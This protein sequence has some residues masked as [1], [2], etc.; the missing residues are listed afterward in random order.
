MANLLLTKF[1]KIVNCKCM[2]LVSIRKNS[3]LTQREA[4]SICGVPYRT[5]VRYEEEGRSR[6]ETRYDMISETLYGKVRIDE[7]HGILSLD[8]IKELLI[9]VLKEHNI[10]YCYL[11]GSYARGEARENSDVDLLVETD[12]TGIDFF[13]LVE[14]IRTKLGKKVDLLRLKDLSP[15]NPI[16]LE[17]LKEGV[18]IL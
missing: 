16:N 14:R 3:G 8:K 6:N 18:K 10:S 2:D 15:N 9:P 17:I 5:Y 12:I 4:A 13:V 1:A 11:F 7:E